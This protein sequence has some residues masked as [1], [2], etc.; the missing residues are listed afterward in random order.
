MPG[1][2]SFGFFFLLRLTVLGLTQGEMWF[3][4][5]VFV[6]SL[7]APPQLNFL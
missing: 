1:D 7:F 4:I 2:L 6:V 5:R 3:V